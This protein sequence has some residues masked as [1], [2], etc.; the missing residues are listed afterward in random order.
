LLSEIFPIMVKENVPPQ[1]TDGIDGNHGEREPVGTAKDVD[2]RKELVGGKTEGGNV[3]ADGGM[4]PVPGP[5]NWD[6]NV[7]LGCCVGVTG[8]GLTGC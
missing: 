7:A 6:G 3:V 1:A 2:G 5:P 4:N 8:D